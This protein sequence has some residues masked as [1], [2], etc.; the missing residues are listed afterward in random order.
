VIQRSLIMC[1]VTNRELC[2]PGEMLFVGLTLV[3]NNPASFD[4]ILGEKSLV[5][6]TIVR[7]RYNE[8]A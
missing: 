7:R 2:R 6:F 4:Y 5:T 8:S 1:S 3:G